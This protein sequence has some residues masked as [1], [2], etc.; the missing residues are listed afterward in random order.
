MLFRGASRIRLWSSTFNIMRCACFTE[1]NV[2]TMPTDPVSGTSIM[3]IQEKYIIY[4][5]HIYMND[6]AN[7][8]K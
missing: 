7:M 1:A 2:A 5:L 8:V 3:S 6:Y 4:D